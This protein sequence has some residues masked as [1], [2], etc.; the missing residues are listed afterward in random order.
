MQTKEEVVQSTKAWI[1]HVIVELNFCPFAGREVKRDSIRYHVVTQSK[2][3]ECLLQLIEECRYLDEHP[4]TETTLVIYPDAFA[5]FDDFLDFLEL[6]NALMHEQGYE[7]VYQLASFH[8]QYRFADSEEED[9]AN[10]TNRSPYP[11]LH[12][13]RE[14]SIEAALKDYPEPEQIPERNITRAR[15]LGLEK[16]RELLEKCKRSET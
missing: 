11:M 14:S 12:L 5:G 7:G 15:E 13:I 3:E 16:M 2:L 8:P 1:N 6:A 9:P 10:Y 4:E